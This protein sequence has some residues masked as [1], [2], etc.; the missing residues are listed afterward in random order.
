MDTY[1]LWKTICQNKLLSGAT[2][3]LLMNKC[4]ILRTKLKS[5]WC[6]STRET[7][8]WLM[9]Q[10]GVQFSNNIPFY[11]GANEFNGVIDCRYLRLLCIS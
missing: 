3:I 11:T 1:D 8:L 10:A 6:T 5:G 2:F 7:R 4:D 9:E